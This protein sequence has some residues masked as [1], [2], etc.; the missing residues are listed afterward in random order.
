MRT[1][2]LVVVALAFT[3][4]VAAKDDK[5]ELVRELELNAAKLEPQK[6]AKV[7]EPMKVTSKAELAKA[8]EDKDAADA[9]A[10]LVDFE[11]EYVLIFAWAGSGGDKLTAAVDKDA[12]IFSV[13]RGL[14]KD[15]RQ[16]AHV[17]AVAK[18]AEWSMAK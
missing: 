10:K 18:N 11:K 5:K 3:G 12:V 13:K 15:L 6:G 4:F 8:V 7:G 17:F 14:T 16:H 1:L 2:M 9:I